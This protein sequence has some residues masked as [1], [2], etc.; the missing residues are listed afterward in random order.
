MNHARVLRILF[1]AVL[2][3]VGLNL[4][5]GPT[6]YLTNGDFETPAFGVPPGTPVTYP[7]LCLGGDSAGDSWSTWVN[8]CD[9]YMSTV[10]L[11]STLPGGGTYMMEVTTSGL[12]GGIYQAFLPPNTGPDYLSGSAWVY[13]ISGC[14]G[15]GLGNDGT[16]AVTSETCTTGQWIELS[17]DNS[18]SPVNEFLIYA[19]YGGADFYVDNAF[20]ATPEPA[21][22]TL[23]AMGIGGSLLRR[24]RSS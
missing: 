10:L 20:V 8:V 4:Y 21:T 5:A 11:P 24:R 18:T 13:L 12:A 3:L 19:M 2:L 16:T 1:M 15:I 6:N 9:S 23:L 22:L 14:V 7:N 17:T